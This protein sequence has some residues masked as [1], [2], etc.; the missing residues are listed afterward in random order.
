MRVISVDAASGAAQAI[1][2][3]QSKTFIDYANKEYLRYLAATH[4]ILW[5]SE[6]D[7]W[8]HLYLYDAE[9]GKVKKQLTR[10]DWVV[11]EVENVDENKREILL[12][13]GG[14]RP[15][16]DPYYIHYARVDFDGNLTAAHRW[17]RH[18]RRGFFAR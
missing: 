4:E 10:G 17:R 1:I 8:N 5:M 6:R 2:D 9:T 18:A 15:E 3:E 11:R 13:V 16:Q 7:G 14:I 12:R